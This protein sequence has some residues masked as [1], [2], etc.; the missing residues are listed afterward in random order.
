M[1]DPADKPPEQLALPLV[2]KPAQGRADFLVSECNALAVATLAAP[3]A[4]PSGR[5]A[6]VGP[7]RSGKSHLA[8][9]WQAETGARTVAAEALGDADPDGLA[10]GPLVVEDV[11]GP[12]PFTAERKFLHLLNLAAERRLALLMT[13]REAPAQ[14]QVRLPDLASRLA[15]AG[16]VRIHAPDDALLSSL[17]IKLAADRHIEVAPHIVAYIAKRMERSFAAL[18]RIIEAL[19]MASLATRRPITRTMAAEI[20]DRPATGASRG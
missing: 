6:L 11:S 16:L 1:T 4:W 14:G 3:A 20:L 15:A 10:R 12:M 18:E 2:W 5:L 7:P 8:A 13:G 17:L 9:V 19:D